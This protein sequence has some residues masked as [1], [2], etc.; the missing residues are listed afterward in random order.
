MTFSTESTCPVAASFR[1]PY[2]AFHED[3]EKRAKR[4]QTQAYCGQCERY[5]WPNQQRAC[6]RFVNAPDPHVS[7]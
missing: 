2:V 5:V 4:G 6:S 1:L 7:E 3:A